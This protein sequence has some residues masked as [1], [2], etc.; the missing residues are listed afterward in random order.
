MDHKTV[1]CFGDSNTHGT[2]AMI[3][4]TEKRR[5]AK[6]ERWP[7][8]MGRLLGEEWDVIA[9][10][11]PGRTSVLDDPVDGSHKNGFRALHA[12]LESHRPIDLTILM[13]GTNDLKARFALSAHDI[14]LCIRRL[15]V[16]IQNS[17]TGL[18]GQAPRVLIAAPTNVIETGIFV[19]MFAGAAKKSVAL[20][21]KLRDLAKSQ[22]VDF[23]DLN[24][25][26]TVDPVDGI[27]L[28]VVGQAAVGVAMAT[29][30]AELIF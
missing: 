1:L 20:T 25:F 29:A 16:E 17:D 22:Q 27:H 14:S 11:H 4:P 30:V 12:I 2:V 15:V 8:V 26:A 7:S 10:G 9:E 6:A 28:D 21:N 24:E 3:S 23:I 13:L 19:E 5:F 18:N